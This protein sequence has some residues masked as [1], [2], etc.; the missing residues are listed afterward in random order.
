MK[1][2][3]SK[4]S[5]IAREA[6]IVEW[7]SFHKSFHNFYRAYGIYINNDKSKLI[8]DEGDSPEIKGITPIFGGE[9]SMFIL[10]IKYLGCI[11]KPKRHRISDLE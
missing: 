8:L 3:E 6:K 5:Q 1:V 11:L 4:G 7:E 10:G 2:V 9:D